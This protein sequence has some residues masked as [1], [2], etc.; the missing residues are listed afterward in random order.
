MLRLVHPGRRHEARDQQ[1][2]GRVV[3]S[4]AGRGSE[5]PRRKKQPPPRSTMPLL[6]FFIAARCC[7]DCESI[8]A[9]PLPEAVLIEA[10]FPSSSHERIKIDRTRAI[11]IRNKAWRE[12]K[13]E[14]QRRERES[15]RRRSS[16]RR[17]RFDDGDGA[18]FALASGFRIRA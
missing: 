6:F 16:R 13:R 9:P 3:Q 2:G 11:R 14:A 18:F 7:P 10:R 5:S 15:E 1:S 4:R 17:R 12:R 8:Q